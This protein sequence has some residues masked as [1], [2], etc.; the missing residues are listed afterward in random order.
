MRFVPNICCTAAISVAARCS[1]ALLYH[2]LCSKTR[3]TSITEK[4]LL[5]SMSRSEPPKKLHQTP[6]LLCLQREALLL[7]KFWVILRFRRVD[8]FFFLS[9][10]FPEL[11]F[12]Q[13]LLLL[14][15]FAQATELT[16]VRS[17]GRGGEHN[18]EYYIL[19]LVKGLTENIGERSR[20]KRLWT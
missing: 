8:F 16:A 6:Q 15:E 9:F 17:V 20:R 10:C 12:R 18:I 5:C 2:H 14:H 11:F 13:T 3:V 1:L 4:D 7:G 19:K